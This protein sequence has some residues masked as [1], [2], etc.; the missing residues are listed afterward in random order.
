MGDDED[1]LKCEEEGSV[2]E[3]WGDDDSEGFIDRRRSPPKGSRSR[4]PKD[5][6]VMKWSES[7][8]EGAPNQRRGRTNLTRRE[9]TTSKKRNSSRP[10]LYA[11]ACGRGG[12]Q[13]TGLFRADW[14][15]VEFLVSGF[16][17]AKFKKVRDESEGIRFIR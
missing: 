8:E 16:S 7:E 11:V 13:S 4:R 12:V 15:E 10:R 2:D 9:P 17:R 5:G 3:E 6:R 1:N 14:D